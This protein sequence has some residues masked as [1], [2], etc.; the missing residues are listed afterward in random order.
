MSVICGKLTQDILYNCSFPEQGGADEEL[1]LINHEDLDRTQGDNGFLLNNLNPTIVEAIY[2]KVGAKAN[3]VKGKRNPNSIVSTYTI[4]DFSSG[5]QHQV[6]FPAYEVS[7]ATVAALKGLEN[8]KV[9]AILRTNQ[10]NSSG[11]NQYKI[12]GKQVGLYLAEAAYNTNENQ[13]VTM[14]TLGPDGD[15]LEPNKVDFLFNTSLATTAALY[16]SLKVAV[17]APTPT[18]TT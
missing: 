18:P 7:P 16:E 11:N 17:P 3:V 8:S 14:I 15:L 13:G 12:A 5:W 1:L 9:L 6:M 2:L 4:Q 10:V